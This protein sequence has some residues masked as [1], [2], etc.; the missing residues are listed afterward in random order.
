MYFQKLFLFESTTIKNTI[1][2]INKCL[3]PLVYNLLSKSTIMR[4]W[5]IFNY[6]V[7]F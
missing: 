4:F 6:K 2:K 3:F 7:Q 5:A 1:E